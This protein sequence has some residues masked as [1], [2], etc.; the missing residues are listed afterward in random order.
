[1]NYP[2]ADVFFSVFWF[3]ALCVWTF[4]VIW[5]IMLIFRRRDLSGWA[6]AAWLVFVIFVPLLGVLAYLVARGGHLAEEQASDYNSPQDEAYRAYSRNEAHGRHR[7]DE[8]TKLADL[9]DRGVIT[10]EEF[11]R[12][13]VQLLG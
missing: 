4:L 7:A 5:T 9:R 8:L 2:L 11:Q 12:G 1:V 3:F 13:K 6:K 10:D